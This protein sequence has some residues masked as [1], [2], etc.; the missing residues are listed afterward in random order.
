MLRLKF[1]LL[2]SLFFPNMLN[3]LNNAITSNVLVLEEEVEVTCD[4]A[5]WPKMGNWFTSEEESNEASNSNA[6]N[7]STINNCSI[8]LAAFGTVRLLSKIATT[9]RLNVVSY[10]ALT[11]LCYFFYCSHLLF[12]MCHDYRVRYYGNYVFYLRSLVEDFGSWRSPKF[13]SEKKQSS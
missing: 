5:A 8:L 6:D 3:M 4:F 1:S 10:T 13:S 7:H 9:I 12:Y 2:L 11:Y